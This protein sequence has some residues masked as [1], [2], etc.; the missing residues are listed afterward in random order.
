[1]RNLWLILAFALMCGCCCHAQDGGAPLK[2]SPDF[3]CGTGC[4]PPPAPPYLPP[5]SACLSIWGI[6]CHPD[7][8]GYWPNQ[9]DQDTCSTFAVKKHQLDLVMAADTIRDCNAAGGGTTQ[10]QACEADR[11]SIQAGIDAEMTDYINQCY[12]AQ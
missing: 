7:P 11:N 12:A 2:P 8:A 3:R 10:I 6:D 4:E 5:S 1:M 9:I